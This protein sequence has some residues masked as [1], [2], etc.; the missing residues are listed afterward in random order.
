M[1]LTSALA[2]VHHLKDYSKY[3]GNLAQLGPQKTGQ[4]QTGDCQSKADWSGTGLLAT[5]I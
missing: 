5:P 1:T 4:G 2:K 3:I